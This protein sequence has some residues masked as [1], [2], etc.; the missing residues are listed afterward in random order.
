MEHIFTLDK[1][2]QYPDI[3]VQSYLRSKTLELA[4][5]LEVKELVYLDTKFWLILRDVTLGNRR[6]PMSVALY[7]RC[8]ELKRNGI[9][10]FPVSQDVILEVMKQS[11]ET[12]R[13]A[14]A[15][16]IDTLSDGVCLIS[17]RERVGLEALQFIADKTGVDVYPV[18]RLVWTKI[19]YALGFVSS[20]PDLD[21][22]YNLAIQKAFIDQMWTATLTDMV[23]MIGF[24][25]KTAELLKVD[26]ADSQNEGKFKYANQNNS[27]RQM[28]QSELAG[29]LDVWEPEL[30]LVMPRLYFLK[31]GVFPNEEQVEACETPSSVSKMIYNLFRLQ[32][33]TNELPTFRIVSGLH[34]AARWDTKRNYENNDFY[35]FQHAACALPYTDYFF[36]EAHLKHA[37]TQGMTGY[38]SLYCCT[39][40]A[41]VSEALKCLEDISKD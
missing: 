40:V 35:D 36:T 21:T 26:I 6:C 18:E 14:T 19:V 3:S 29:F 38:D 15:K 24:D 34:A 23:K 5:D 10:V 32:K 11:D 20:K 28:F 17:L 27:F 33:I 1:H 37:I 2:L 25:E 30:K 8:F 39:V 41:K 4:E 12:T 13:V 31:T 22:A 7:E 16:V 9:C